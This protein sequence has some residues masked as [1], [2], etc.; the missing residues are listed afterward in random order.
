ME[1]PAEIEP[2][3]RL[4]AK[5]AMS[6]VVLCCVLIACTTVVTGR[7]SALESPH[8]WDWQYGRVVPRSP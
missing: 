3:F 7:D 5:W 6:I 2:E 8:L 1:R 4:S